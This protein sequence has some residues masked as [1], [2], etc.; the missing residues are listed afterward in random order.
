MKEKITGI[1][2]EASFWDW[3]AYCCNAI[4]LGASEL[5]M[6]RGG[7][8]LDFADSLAKGL[9]E[10]VLP[11]VESDYPQSAGTLRTVLDTLAKYE[12]QDHGV[13]KADFGVDHTT[14]VDNIKKFMQ[15]IP[16]LS[17]RLITLGQYIESGKERYAASISGQD[18]PDHVLKPPA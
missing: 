3:A 13:D 6:N 15:E 5:W 11:V 16:A 7:C 1:W 4:H 10:N 2:E 8:T 18:V 17:I 14:V 12:G 9:A